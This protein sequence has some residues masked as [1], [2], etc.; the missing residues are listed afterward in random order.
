METSSQQK[1][2]HQSVSTNSIS[3]VF[4]PYLQSALFIEQSTLHS[5]AECTLDCGKE[6]NNHENRERFA[7]YFKLVHEWLLFHH[8]MKYTVMA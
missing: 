2:Y 1:D 4:L 5:N 7:N 8:S 6:I 3:R